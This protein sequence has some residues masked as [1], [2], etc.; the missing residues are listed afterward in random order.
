MV[1]GFWCRKSTPLTWAD[2]DEETILLHN[3]LLLEHQRD[4]GERVWTGPKSTERSQKVFWDISC[5][6]LVGALA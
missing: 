2:A 3:L 4:E 1:A 6:C 5:L